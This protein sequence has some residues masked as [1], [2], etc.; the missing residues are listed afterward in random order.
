MNCL[1]HAK[2]EFA[3]R[4]NR[5][6]IEAIRVWKM[7]SSPKDIAAREGAED[8]T[9]SGVGR[10]PG[11]P[12]AGPRRHRLTFCT[13]WYIVYI[14][15]IFN[16]ILIWNPNTFAVCRLCVCYLSCYELISAQGC[17]TTKSSNSSNKSRK[18][19]EKS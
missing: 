14:L 8:Q 11:R 3:Q 16:C 12:A 1:T 18:S 6:P 13:P 4:Y 5:P 2:Q 17:N 19:S 7:H 10:N 9:G 15:D